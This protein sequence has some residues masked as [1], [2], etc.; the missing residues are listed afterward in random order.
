MSDDGLHVA[1]TASTP[2]VP[3]TQHLCSHG[4][5]SLCGQPLDVRTVERLTLTRVHL[6]DPDRALLCIPCVQ[7]LAR[8]WA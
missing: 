2:G 3:V 8:M 7:V 1:R 6:V 5:V 4:P